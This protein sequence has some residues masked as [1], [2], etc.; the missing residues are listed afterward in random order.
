VALTKEATYKDNL[1]L[2]VNESG[3][4]EW[5]PKNPGNIKS[6]QATG[7][8]EGNGSVKIYIEKDGKRYLAYSNK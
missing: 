5:Q 4:Y 6:I 8:V 1:N 7:S 2:K 3:T